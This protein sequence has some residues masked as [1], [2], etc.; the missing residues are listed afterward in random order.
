M[1]TGPACDDYQA[2]WTVTGI[3]PTGQPNITT[4]MFVNLK[5]CR[6]YFDIDSF[7]RMRQIWVFAANARLQFAPTDTM[8]CPQPPCVSHPGNGDPWF[9]GILEY[10]SEP[11][12]PGGVEPP[13]GKGGE[14]PPEPPTQGC[15]VSLWLTHGVGCLQHFDS[16][17]YNSQPIPAG[18]P[19][20]HDDTSFHL[21]APES[22]NVATGLAVPPSS[23]IDV[24]NGSFDALRSTSRVTNPVCRTEYPMALGTVNLTTMLIDCSCV[25]PAPNTL[26]FHQDVMGRSACAAQQIFQSAGGLIPALPTGFMQYFLGQFMLPAGMWPGNRRVWNNGGIMDYNDIDCGAGQQPTFHFVYG[27]TSFYP[28]GQG[29]TR[30]LFPQPGGPTGLLMMCDFVNSLLGQDQPLVGN[31]SRAAMLWQISR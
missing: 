5:Y 18:N 21:V 12:P 29:W 19:L 24:T 22:F 15:A 23:D 13:P 4:P 9:T 17:L 31:N 3:G 16:P 27:G 25:V 10:A 20:A 1:Q 26:H 8:P 6:T 11:D 2:T 7:G 28:T 30:Q 14:E